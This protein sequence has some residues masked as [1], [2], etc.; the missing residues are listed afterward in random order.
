MSCIGVGF[1]ECVII[2]IA[3]GTMTTGDI[4]EEEH[5]EDE[6]QRAKYK[7]LGDTLGQNSPR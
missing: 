3:V 5:V 7:T 2:A 4:T 6:Q 1:N